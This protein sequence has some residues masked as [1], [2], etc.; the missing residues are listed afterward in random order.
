MKTVCLVL[1]KRYQYFKDYIQP[2]FKRRLNL[3]VVP[4]L[5]GDGK[6]VEEIPY[7]MVDTNELPPKLQYSTDY[8]SW[9]QRP[10]AYNAWKC[11]HQIFHNAVVDGED[12]LFLLEDDV[13]IADNFEETA[14]DIEQLKCEFA[15]DLLY[16]GSYNATRNGQKLYQSMFGSSPFL[17]P[18][19]SECGGFHAII[20][21]R[22]ALKRLILLPPCSPFDTLAS[23]Y[24]HG[25]LKCIA[26]Y[27]SIISQRS[28]HSFVEDRY[29]NKPTEEPL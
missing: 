9:H 17:L 21:S 22:K 12:H 19:L 13:V 23:R 7:D 20:L 1:D 16:L 28:G 24:L 10:A 11:H 8:P 26:L 25:F 3:D 2:E 18:N 29:L 15:A 6:L 4:F 27:P 5:G 14:S